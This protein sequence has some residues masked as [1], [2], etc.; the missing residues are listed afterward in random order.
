M[1]SLPLWHIS[2]CFNPS[3]PPPPQQISILL[4]IPICIVMHCSASTP[5]TRYYNSFGTPLQSYFHI[6]SGPPPTILF[7]G[8]ALSVLCSNFILEAF[9]LICFQGLIGQNSWPP[10]DLLVYIVYMCCARVCR[11]RA[12]S[13]MV[14]VTFWFI[15][16]WKVLTLWQLKS[17][18][19]VG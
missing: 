14:C 6:F 4:A 16:L 2:V 3:S 13:C 1:F 5:P 9:K 17:I 12:Y 7:N 11:T 10:E 15:V 18:F 19:C 8:I